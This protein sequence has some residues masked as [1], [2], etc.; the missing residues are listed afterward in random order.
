MILKPFE[1]EEWMT[2]HENSAQFNMTDTCVQSPS[3]EELSTLTGLDLNSIKLDYGEITGS[4]PLKEAILSLYKTGAVDQITTVNGCL[5]ANALVLDTLL[6]KGDHVIC[7]VPGYQQFY[8]YPASLGCDVTKIELKEED[9]WFPDPEAV[10]KVI[11]PETVLLI[12]NN[13]SNPTGTFFDKELLM[14]LIELCRK[15]GIWILA[16]EVYLDL[17]NCDSVSDLYEKGISTS[18]LSKHYGLAGLRLGWIKA[19]AGLIKRINSRR[20]YTM[21]S[22]GPLKDAVGYA[23]LQHRDKILNRSRTIIETNKKNLVRWLEKNPEYDV[24]LPKRG[25]VCF[26]KYNYDY[27]SK[28]LAETLLKEEGIFFVPGACFE[29]ENH[30]RLGLG[31]SEEMFADGLNALSKWTADRLSK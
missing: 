8:D 20:D 18:S 5:E 14:K 10:A 2:D 26:L 25:T 7:F 29:L 16:D 15:Q 13:P 11:R 30:L 17:D 9:N 12:V 31:Q 4:L 19:D 27:E 21:I 23:V 3:W 6:E 1:V 22:T 28:L 24:V